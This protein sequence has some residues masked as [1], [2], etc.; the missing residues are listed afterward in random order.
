M[1]RRGSDDSFE[2]VSAGSD[3]D[4]WGDD[5][6]VGELEASASTP[7]GS[8]LAGD[9]GSGNA[10]PAGGAGANGA[11]QGRALTDT[12]YEVLDTAGI[13]S[14]M[15][16]L[17]KGVSGLV[18]CDAETAA[19]LL[20]RFRW[21]RDRLV[22]S[23]YGG[24]GDTKSVSTFGLDGLSKEAPAP[25]AS[26]EVECA[27]CMSDCAV[28]DTYALGACNHRFCLDCWSDYL[29]DQLDTKGTQVCLCTC[30]MFKCTCVVPPRVFRSVLAG[31]RVYLDKYRAATIDAFVMECKRLRWCPAPRCRRAIAAVGGAV[32]AVTCQCGN[33]FCFQCQEEGHRPVTC[34]QVL[35]WRRKCLKESENAQWILSNTKKCPEC[36]VHI[37]KN[38]GCNHITCQRCSHE[39]CWVCMGPW[40]THGKHTGGFYKCNK[41]DPRAEAA[42]T[43]SKIEKRGKDGELDRFLHYYQ[44]YHNHAHARKFAR[45]QIAKAETRMAEL[46]RQRKEATWMDVQFLVDATRQVLACRQVLQYTY[47]YGYYC[48][49]AKERAFFEFLQEQLE[50]A[51]E[52]LSELSERPLSKIQ[53]QRVVDMTTSTGKFLENL[54]NGIDRGLLSDGTSG[55]TS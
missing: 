37:E 22:A 45:A 19:M 29:V 24:S 2:E 10:G 9:E 38:Q 53:R 18:G 15:N 28:K 55:G 47:I 6:D 44:R 12:E 48:S 52:H 41:Y 3:A 34:E 35:V 32:T 11:A 31:N 50:K 39:F 14:Y 40:A 23:M 20:R 1:S 5:D 33:N 49:E 27:I 13:E 25:A 8:R 30:P 26:E 16:K 54:L 4:D 21:S 46:H 42:R 43:D 17:V 7:S 51:T 36:G